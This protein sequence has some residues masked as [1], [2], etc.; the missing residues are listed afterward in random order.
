[1]DGAKKVIPR[2]AAT[3]IAARDSSGTLEVLMLRRNLQS[4][5]GR[6]AF[7]FPGGTLDSSD[8]DPDVQARCVGLT[9]SKASAVLGL[10]SGGLAY[11]VAALRECFEEAGLLLAYRDGELLRFDQPEVEMRFAEH[12]NAINHGD[13]GF[14]EMCRV[15]DLQLAVDRV[16]YV[17]NW[18]TPEGLPR[19][20]DTRFFVAGAPEGQVPMHDSRE[21]IDHIWVSPA[22]AIRRH[23][24][25][26]I[27]LML[28]TMR[29]LER[30]Q[31]YGS[32]RDL[33]AKHSGPRT[34]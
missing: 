17:A 4:A 27:E 12:R 28:P 5:F 15:E 16:H 8:S 24:S 30:L 2:P 18:V 21:T 7:V 9:D 3:I 19:R 11:W 13:L 23:Q 31:S 34:P 25:G 22:E 1:M 6:G 14:P 29:N 10:D 33:L 20:Y 32:V 26:E